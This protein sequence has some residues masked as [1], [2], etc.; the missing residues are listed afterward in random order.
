VSTRRVIATIW[1]G[2]ISVSHSSLHSL[3]S[4]MVV[5]LVLLFRQT[6]VIGNSDMSVES[7][8]LR[9]GLG[10]LFIR[11]QSI[12]RESSTDRSRQVG[13]VAVLKG[14]SELL[15]LLSHV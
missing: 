1:R 10:S 8:L 3:M 9:T 14:H 7:I 6:I 12:E 11:S 15:I 4:A 13:E 2:W 5:G